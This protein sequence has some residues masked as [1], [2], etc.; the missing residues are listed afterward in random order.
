M[1][2]TLY[3]HHFPIR[4]KLQIT[5]YKHK[6]M[7]KYIK[8]LCMSVVGSL[9]LAGCKTTSHLQAEREKSIVVLFENDVHCSLEGYS[10]LAGLRDAI[11]DTAHVAL[12]SN[13]DYLQGGTAGAISHGQYIVDIMKHMRYDAVTLGNH[14]FDYGM[15]RMH[16]LLNQLNT[17]VV[18]ANLLDMSK[19]QVFAPYVI[20]TYGKKKV[21]FVGVVTPTA[22]YTEEY[23]FFDET[24]KQLNELAEKNTYQLVQ[25]A[26]LD[27]RRNGADYV[28]VISHLGEDKNDL[29]VDAYGLIENTVGIDALLDGHT[30]DAIPH[31]TKKNKE[32][33]DVLYAQTGTQFKNVG[34]LLFMPDGSKKVTIIP[35]ANIEV[36]NI[37]VKQATDSVLQLA[38]ELINRP[39]C[40]SD[41]KLRILTPEGRQAVRLGETNAGDIVTD[42]YRIMTGADFAITNGGGIRSEMEAGDITYG[43]MVSL[44]PYDNY[45]C[46][47]EITGEQLVD[48]LKA[49]TR[50]LPIENG[51]FPQVSGIK[52]T[53]NVGKEDLVTDVL[54]LDAASQEYKPVDLS[55]T[56]TLATIDYC[57]TGGGLQSKL[58]KN[59]VIKNKIMIYNEC[60]I[61]Y[62]TEKLQSHITSQYAEPQGRITIN[63]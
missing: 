45:V 23:A 22:L 53:I 54:I 25:Q 14:E 8:Y 43:D 33:H 19:K 40:K 1:N 56:Y 36:M 34:K 17:N 9:L 35:T 13:G 18:C 26:V 5:S 3:L 59:K 50:F 46:T 27:A 60:L 15:E 51:D 31:V 21:A 4:W 10:R 39:I 29:N 57:I 6:A 28:V 16:E 30:H 62:V 61:N 24:G 49:C 63:Y 32:G 44:L 48:L 41:V 58:K 37:E 11:S 47:V 7:N 42:A 2:K 55:R 38:N 52:Y 20:K 12:V